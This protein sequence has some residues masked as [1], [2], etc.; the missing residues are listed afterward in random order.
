MRTIELNGYTIEITGKED[1]SV[2]DDKHRVYAKYCV[3]HQIQSSFIHEVPSDETWKLDVFC[4]GL[5][6]KKD[7]SYLWVY[8][9]DCCSIALLWK[10]Y[11]AVIH[12]WRK[13]L[14]QWI[15]FEALN[16]LEQKKENIAE[17]VVC[18]W[19]S[20]KKEVYEVWREFY[21]YFPRRFLQKIDWNLTLDM[22]E[23]AISQLEYR[24][25]E[26]KN[27]V[28]DKFCTYQNNDMYFSHRRGEP[29][30]N[31]FGVSKSKK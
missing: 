23:F 27:I 6:W 12:W 17:L 5:I 21:N 19:P 8:T 9:W 1:G 24:G 31:F 14:Y 15:L 4:D 3:A 16:R 28:V 30:R 2:R 18:F 22:V 26:E 10:N 11:F 25:V 29:G 13:T 20:I 7:E